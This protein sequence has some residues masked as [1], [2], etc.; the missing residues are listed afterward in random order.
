M[1]AEGFAL[2]GVGRIVGPRGAMS[3]T[4]LCCLFRAKWENLCS[5]KTLVTL[6][7]SAQKHEIFNQRL[8]EAA[9]LSL[10]LGRGALATR[11]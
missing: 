9:T 3:P 10:S 6:L 1:L 5:A 7:P 8:A 11:K 2:R 4:E